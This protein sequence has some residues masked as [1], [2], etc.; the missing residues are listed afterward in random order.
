VD[1]GGVGQRRYTAGRD[2]LMSS[3]GGSPAACGW[4]R[5]PGGVRSPGGGAA[6]G[7]RCRVAADA[8]DH[9]VDAASGA[10]PV[11]RFPPGRLPARL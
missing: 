8:L 5:P 3:L 1:F 7:R 9:P 6:F 4:W 10:R 11:G 2:G